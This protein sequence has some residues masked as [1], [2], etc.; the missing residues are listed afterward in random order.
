MSDV[1]KALTLIETAYAELVEENKNLKANL[2]KMAGKL[3]KK[4]LLPPEITKKVSM[5][6]IVKAWDYARRLPEYDRI[7][8]F[9]GFMRNNKLTKEFF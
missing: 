3:S 1:I 6:D 8:E 2:S 5:S 9:D 4:N 7:Q